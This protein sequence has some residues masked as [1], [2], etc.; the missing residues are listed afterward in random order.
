M[1]EIKKCPIC[2][3]PSQKKFLV[4]KDYTVSNKVFSIVE[5]NSCGFR[6]TNPIPEEKEIGHYYKSKDYVSHS[7]TKKGIINSIYHLVRKHTLAQKKRLA[8]SLSEEKKLL[9]IGCGTGDFINYLN[10]KKWN[11]LGLEPDDETRGYA[12][13]TKNVNVQSIEFIS[14]IEDNSFPVVSMWHVLEHV[15][16]LDQQIQEISRILKEQGKLIVAVPNSNSYDA[17]KYKSFWAAYDLPRH[18]YHFR[19]EDIKRLFEKHGFELVK[20][21]PM[22]FDSYYISM[23]SEKYKGGKILNGFI[24]GIISNKKAKKNN[25]SSL[26]YILRLKNS[27]NA[28]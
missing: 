15:Y 1:K 11:T 12:V 10:K 19:K 28:K 3:S 27:K 9:D 4:C 20:I 7:G 25:H 13:K 26:T 5:C 24:N 6:F 21:L 17:K 18:L 23:I 2:E 16:Q 22:K 14:E 8:D